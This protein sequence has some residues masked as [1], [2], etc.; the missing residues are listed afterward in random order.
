MSDGGGFTGVDLLAEKYYSISPYAYCAG[1]PLNNVDPDGRLLTDF[2]DGDGNLVKHID[3]GSSAVF[4]QT[5]TGVNLHYELNGY[6]PNSDGSKSPNLTSAIQEQQQLNLQNPA[7]QQNAEGY[8]ET[9]CN[10]ATQNVMKTVDSAID[11]KTPIVVNGRANDMAA[12]LSSGKNPNYLSV[13]EST[14]SKNAQNGGLSIVDYTNPNP[15]K[16]GHIATYSVGVNILEGKIANIGPSSYTGFVP[17]NGAIGKNKP[18]EYFILQPNV[19]PT[20]T[21]VGQKR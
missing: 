20:V 21:V 2:E 10:Q 19:L 12:T 11:N 5:G 8:N 3:D 6:N 7:L 16:S 18:K 4:Q 14:A 13:S 17:L 1:D 15:S 9:H